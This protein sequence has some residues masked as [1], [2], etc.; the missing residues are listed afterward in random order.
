MKADKKKPAPLNPDGKWVRDVTPGGR[1]WRWVSNTDEAE[2]AE[3][4]D[5]AF[6]Q[7]ALDNFPPRNWIGWRFIAEKKE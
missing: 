1:G 4:G 6:R 2:D 3:P 5:W 7:E